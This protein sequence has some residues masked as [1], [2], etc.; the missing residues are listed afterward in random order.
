MHGRTVNNFDEY[1]SFIADHVS[2]KW[3]GYSK[4]SADP[5]LRL[6]E[7]FGEPESYPV[8]IGLEWEATSRGSIPHV[9]AV[10]LRPVVNRF[11]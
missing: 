8:N 2:D 5:E 4:A 7:I 3:R 9:G 6:E 1:V 10:E 11:A